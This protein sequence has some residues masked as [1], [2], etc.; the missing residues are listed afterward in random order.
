MSGRPKLNSKLVREW[1]KSEDRKY[2]YLV[3]KLEVSGS[4]VSQMLCDG[5]VPQEE[6]L[7]R[8]ARLMGRLVG[9]L[10]IYPEAK[11]AG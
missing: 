6:T 5:H 2:S 1:L 10:L 11:K 4:L 8:L 3:R 7:S 9:D